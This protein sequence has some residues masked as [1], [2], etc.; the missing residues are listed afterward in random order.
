MAP[1]SEDFRNDLTAAHTPEQVLDVIEPLI[2]QVLSDD[3]A[4]DGESAMSISETVVGPPLSLDETEWADLETGVQ[5][6]A[7][8]VDLTDDHVMGGVDADTPTEYD[9]VQPETPVAPE[10]TQLSDER[11][12]ASEPKSQGRY[13]HLFSKL[14]RQQQKRSV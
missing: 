4:W 14:R 6:S 11:I 10:K 1:E 12:D 13:A 7:G 5:E 9:V 2:S 3:R 8:F